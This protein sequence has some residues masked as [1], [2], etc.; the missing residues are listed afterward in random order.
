MSGFTP[1]CP[2]QVEVLWADAE[3]VAVNKPWGLLVHNS[4]YAGRPETSLKQIVSRQ[5]GA[6][7]VPIHRLD[8]GTSGVVLFARDTSYVAGWAAALADASSGKRYVGLVR[9]RPSFD[10]VMVDHPLRL[11]NGVAQDAQT[12]IQV[13]A[14]ST[15]A[16]CSLVEAELHTGRKHQI[17]RHLAHLRHPVIH[18]SVHGDAKFNRAFR[19]EHGLSRMALHAHTLEVVHPTEGQRV[20]IAAPLPFDLREPLDALFYDQKG[21]V[22][23]A[24]GG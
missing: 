3:V 17:R 10:R 14:R 15:V 16:R 9:G 23:L 2:D 13:L 6:T 20:Q 19:A 7:V 24:L 4:A 11:A 22:A 5:L 12:D 1:P 21:V 8:R 18:D